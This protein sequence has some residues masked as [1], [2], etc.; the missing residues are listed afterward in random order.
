MFEQTAFPWT[1]ATLQKRLRAAVL[2][3]WKGRSGQGSVQGKNG[4]KDT[5]TRSEVTGGQHL[6]QFIELIVQTALAAGFTTTEIKL[7]SGIELPGYFRPQKKWDLVVTRADRVCAAV[8][9][10]S[11]VGSFGN[12]FNN[13]RG[14]HWQRHRFLDRL[15]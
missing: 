7:G 3:Y 15:S 6:N 2:S 13:R 10:K 14:G 9:L 4:A 11:Q 1:E 8:E 12:N 5:G